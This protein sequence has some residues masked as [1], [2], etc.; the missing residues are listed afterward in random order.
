MATTESNTMYSSKRPDNYTPQQGYK[1][2]L[3]LADFEDKQLFAKL[4]RR[5]YTGELNYTKIVKL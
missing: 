4:R 1:A 2:M 5:G 3:S